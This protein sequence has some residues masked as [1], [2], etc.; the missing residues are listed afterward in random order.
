MRLKRI[1]EMLV[2]ALSV[3]AAMAIVSL[4]VRFGYGPL[5]KAVVPPLPLPA[6]LVSHAPVTVSQIALLTPS[7]IVGLFAMAIL[8][9]RDGAARTARRFLNLQSIAGASFCWLLLTRL[10]QSIL[11]LT[12]NQSLVA[13]HLWDMESLQIIGPVTLYVPAAVAGWIVARIAPRTGVQSILW[14][15][16]VSFILNFVDGIMQAGLPFLFLVQ[17]FAPMYVCLA[18]SALTFGGLASL[19]NRRRYAP[20]A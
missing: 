12:V 1:P 4:L 6:P 15:V 7:L 17:G 11:M 20:A 18:A 14:G 19:L 9:L 13:N 3:V 8:F 2:T 10:S 16:G 5:M